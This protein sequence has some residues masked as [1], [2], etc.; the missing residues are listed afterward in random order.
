MQLGLLIASY[1]LFHIGLYGVFQK[2]GIPGW[3]A[4]VPV[5]G[6][7][8]WLKIIG[9][10]PVYWLLFLIPIVNLFVLVSVIVDTYQSFGKYSFWE[11]FIGV[12]FAP[13]YMIYLGFIDKSAQY[14][15]PS[16][17]EERAIK[18]ILKDY[19]K[20]K[21][22]V[23]PQ[24][25]LRSRIAAA[26]KQG[27]T[28]E[29][30]RLEK[31]YTALYANPYHKSPAREWAEAILFAVFAAHFIR[32]LLIEAFVIPTQSMEGSLLVGDFLFVSKWSYGI[33]LPMT[34]LTIPLIHNNIPGLGAE[35]YTEAV[36]WDY[37]R[38]LGSTD[39]VEIGDPIVFNYPAGDTVLYSKNTGFLDYYN[40]QYQA[41]SQGMLAPNDNMAQ[42]FRENGYEVRTRPIDKR[43]HYIKRSVALPGQT[44]EVRDRTVYTDGKRIATPEHLQYQYRIYG[45]VNDEKFEELRFNMD[46]VVRAAESQ[47]FIVAHMD[48][49]QLKTLAALPSV[50]SIRVIEQPPSL[51][52]YPHRPDYFRW[53]VDNFGPLT[54]PAEGMTIPLTP[55]NV[56]LY[57]RAIEAYEGHRLEERDGNMYL[58]GQ[59]ATEYT[60]EQDYFFGM[61]DNRHN[62]VDSRMWGF[63]PSDHMVGKPLV[64][65]FSVKDG[66]I[67]W[68]RIFRG[69]ESIGE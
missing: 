35:S 68:R 49:S 40:T 54:V 37:R 32:S 1:I 23:P 41:M 18:A 48:S 27:N 9:R 69:A 50:D 38:I 66:N 29:A 16:V 7:I 61:G 43:D 20:N 53:S 2:A 67:R 15:G 31:E 58:D 24:R 3:K 64:V 51:Y 47:G 44:I 36:K 6:G 11:H 34:P 13:L 19:K 65:W 10:K 4:L 60:F 25:K 42:T 22:P 55:E 56:I 62:S 17:P 33:R 21:R 12:V 8:E 26:K 57:R 5:Y 52:V 14:L 30:A 28:E 59:P 63:I 46:D 45:R 39:Q